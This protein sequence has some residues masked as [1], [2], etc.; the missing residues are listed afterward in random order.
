MYIHPNL[1][2]YSYVINI[3]R[4]CIPGNFE[5]PT[6]LSNT[7][8]FLRWCPRQAPIFT[9]L[10]PR[11]ISLPGCV[12]SLSPTP[13]ARLLLWPPAC[14]HARLLL[15]ACTPPSLLLLTCCTSRAHLWHPLC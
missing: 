7:A 6:F 10:M 11:L 5:P 2:Y 12:P 13:H 15:L 4:G 14:P 3:G 1:Y 9:S 8:R